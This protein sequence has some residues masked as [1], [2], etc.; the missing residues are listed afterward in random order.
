[1]VVR[2]SLEHDR[3]VQL[4]SEGAGQLVRTEL[5]GNAQLLVRDQ[6]QEAE[7]L[8]LDRGDGAEDVA[9]GQRVRARPA[10]HPR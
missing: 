2:S 3:A 7:Q 5:V 1:M 9:D 10:R 4:A 6:E 8:G